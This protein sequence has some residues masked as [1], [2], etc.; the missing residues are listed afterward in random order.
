MPSFAYKGVATNGRNVS[1][2]VEAD[3]TRSARARLRDQGIFASQLREAEPA[4]DTS[5][6]TSMRRGLPAR[7]LARAMR[8]LATL[9]SAGIPLVDAVSSLRQ[10]PLRPVLRAALDSVRA[11]LTSGESFHAA[12]E[13]HP[14]VFP[15]IYVGMIRAG[16]ASGALD[17]V[18]ASI[19]DHAET[20]ANLQAQ[21]RTAMTYPIIMMLVGS[22]IV[23]FLL[24][25]V[26]PQVTRVFLE[27]GQVLP[28][29]TRTV[30][31]SSTSYSRLSGRPCARAE[32][33][34]RV[35][36]AAPSASVPAEE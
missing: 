15:P 16:E 29:P 17:H 8:Q 7:E 31:R 9:I 34:A 4:T 10:R 6:A 1:G 12:C 13:K 19:A 35:A 3:T 30:P 18:L 2:V 32:D 33:A 27:S 23:T 24:A 11:D 36:A 28:V 22:A 25:Y 20:N 5:I 14:Q 21:L 26:V